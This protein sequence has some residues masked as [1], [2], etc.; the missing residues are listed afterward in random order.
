MQGMTERGGRWPSVTRELSPPEYLLVASLRRWVAGLRQNNGA[1]WR[2]VSVEFAGAFGAAGG[3]EA[4]A[5]FGRAAGLLQNHP[6]EG[7]GC[8]LPCFPR[9]S[10][11]EGCFMLLV[12]ACQY[13][14]ARLARAASG[15]LVTEE[16]VGDLMTAAA[17][18]ARAM[19]QRGLLLPRR[20]DRLPT[21]TPEPA[22]GKQP[23]LH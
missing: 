23:T 10:I 3:T 9:L 22:A 12:A 1:H 15:W 13:G 8:H 16:A 17:T 4:L 11:H 14:D 20:W 19:R 6:R 21:A 7:L 18:L 5:A 2:V